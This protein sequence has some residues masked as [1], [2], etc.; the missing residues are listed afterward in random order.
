[1]R[2]HRYHNALATVIAVLLAVLVVGRFDTERSSS[3]SLAQGSSS[4]VRGAPPADQ[5]ETGAAARISAAE[6]RKIMITQLKEITARLDRLDAAL[7][8]GIDVRVKEMPA[9]KKDGE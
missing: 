8:A 1:M 9:S 5:D 3:V 6:Q 2:T 7:R 4:V